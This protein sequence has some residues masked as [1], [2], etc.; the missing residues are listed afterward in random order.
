MERLCVRSKMIEPGVIITYTLTDRST[1]S[2]SREGMAW[3]GVILQQ[4]LPQSGSEV[5]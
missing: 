5:A 3:K 4:P 1:A 2:T